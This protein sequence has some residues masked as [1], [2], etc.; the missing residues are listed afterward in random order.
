[1]VVAA[2]ASWLRLVAGRRAVIDTGSI[3]A[4]VA[5]GGRPLTASSEKRF[6]ATPRVVAGRNRSSS[7]GGGGSCLTTDD[8]PRDSG[9]GGG[10]VTPDDS[11][12][13]NPLWL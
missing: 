1:L 7:D 8:R 5:C 6:P 11:D 9:S 4:D 2:P 3:D 10:D 13:E 12:D